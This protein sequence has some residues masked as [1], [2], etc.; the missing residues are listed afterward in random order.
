MH[1][2]ADL[3]KQKQKIKRIR[4]AKTEDLH[5]HADLKTHRHILARPRYKGDANGSMESH[6]SAHGSDTY[7][8]T[9]NYMQLG[10]RVSIKAI[11]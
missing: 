4:K 8:T 1:L 3:K 9:P 7:K 6:G 2:H 5:C 10:L 11:V